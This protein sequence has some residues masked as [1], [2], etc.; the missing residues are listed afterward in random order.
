MLSVPVVWIVSQRSR[1]GDSALGL[2]EFSLLFLELLSQYSVLSSL[3]VKEGEGPG[4]GRSRGGK[5]A[6]E[7]AWQCCSRAAVTERGRAAPPFPS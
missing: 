1:F 6:P 4:M 7:A 2:W 3:R 5:G